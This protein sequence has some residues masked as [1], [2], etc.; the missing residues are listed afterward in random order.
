[1]ADLDLPNRV[2]IATPNPGHIDCSKAGSIV[3]SVG[4]YELCQLQ[5]RTDLFD[6]DHPGVPAYLE[7]SE[8]VVIPGL[9]ALV[10][11]DYACG[12]RCGLGQSYIIV[13]SPIIGF[14]HVW[15]FTRWM[16]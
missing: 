16:W 3:I 14:I 6:W 12:K 9:L 10:D 8:R 13:D 11:L 15:T 2:Y 4:R 7:I 1:M 5:A